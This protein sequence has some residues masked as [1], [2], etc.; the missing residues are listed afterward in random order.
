M[1]NDS[2]VLNRNEL[3]QLFKTIHKGS[4]N[5]DGITTIG[6]VGY[7]NVGKSSTINSLMV[8]KKFQCQLHLVKQNIFK[9]YI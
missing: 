8:E 4:K 7:P 3:I 9:H 5:I 6:L 1:K 2:K